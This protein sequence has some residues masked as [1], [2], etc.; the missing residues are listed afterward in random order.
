MINKFRCFLGLKEAEVLQFDGKFYSLIING[1]LE[2]IKRSG[3]LF[4]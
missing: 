1:H 2:L 3:L 4:I